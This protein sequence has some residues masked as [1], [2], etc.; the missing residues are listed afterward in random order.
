MPEELGDA[1]DRGLWRSDVVAVVK[2]GPRMPGLQSGDLPGA[3]RLFRPLP[4][5]TRGAFPTRLTEMDIGVAD[6]NQQSQIMQDIVKP[7]WANTNVKGF[8]YWGYINGDTWRANTG[9]MS[10]SG[11]KRAALTWLMGFLNR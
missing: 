11:T 4:P 2:H 6:D 9:L 1:R 3:R 10:A 5:A 7:L 8:A